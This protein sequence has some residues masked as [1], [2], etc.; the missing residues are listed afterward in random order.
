[1][2]DEHPYLM[3]ESDMATFHGAIDAF[4]EEAQVDVIIEECLEL[5]L[6]LQQNRRGRYVTNDEIAE[7]VADVFVA[8]NQ[9]ALMVGED[10]VQEQLDDKMDRLVH[11][12]NSAQPNDV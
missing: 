7:E 10:D 6:I 3:G 11:R 8:A 5:A 4:G 2:T 1:M 9:A 12:I